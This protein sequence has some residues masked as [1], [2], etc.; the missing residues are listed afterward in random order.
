MGPLKN[1]LTY[2]VFSWKHFQSLKLSNRCMYS[3]GTEK[4]VNLIW[5]NFPNKTQCL[6]K[7][8]SCIKWI[9][10]F[11]KKCQ[12]IYVNDSKFYLDSAEGNH[13]WS[14]VQCTYYPN[15][16][17]LIFNYLFGS[18]IPTCGVNPRHNFQKLLVMLKIT[19][20]LNFFPWMLHWKFFFQK[21]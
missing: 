17:F 12:I 20:F 16:V 2:N 3:I 7:I 14:T 19:S 15:L 6:K 10:I 1:W 21:H 18:A 9:T 8:V 4:S 5:L 13:F 11:G